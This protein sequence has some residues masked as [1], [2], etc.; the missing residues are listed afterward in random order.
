MKIQNKSKLLIFLI[1]E[2]ITEFNFNY[3]TMPIV[4]TIHMIKLRDI[5][6]KIESILWK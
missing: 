4:A 3:I 6:E 5:V 2:W 1:V